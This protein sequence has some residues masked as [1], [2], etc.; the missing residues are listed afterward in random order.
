[1]ANKT[2]RRNDSVIKNYV[3]TTQVR[4]F[5]YAAEYYYTT[6]LQFGAN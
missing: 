6:V 2:I 1:M 4:N 3:K 5:G